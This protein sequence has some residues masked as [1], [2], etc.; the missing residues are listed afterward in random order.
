MAVMA[1]C[2]TTQAVNGAVPRGGGDPAARVGR[3]SGC[4]PPLARDHERLLDHLLGDVDIA[5]ETDQ[6]GD[7]PAGFL[8]EDPFEVGCVDGRHVRV[9]T[10]ARPG[11]GGPRPDPCKRRTL[12]PP[13]P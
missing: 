6:G 10:R 7:D 5:E 3:Q 9:R 1:G 2:L 12:S 13:T 11:T 8:T 4:R